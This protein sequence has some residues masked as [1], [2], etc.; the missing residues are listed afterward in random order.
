MN[1]YNS[2]QGYRG[3]NGSSN[4]AATTGWVD[5]VNIGGAPFSQWGYRLSDET[6]L[7]TC[8]LD[9]LSDKGSFSHARYLPNQSYE[10]LVRGPDSLGSRFDA[11][12]PNV[13]GISDLCGRGTPS[14]TYPSPFEL[15]TNPIHC[16]DAPSSACRYYS[17]GFD[18]EIH[19]RMGVD[20]STD[21]PTLSG[22][23]FNA[24]QLELPRCIR[25]GGDQIRSDS[26]DILAQAIKGF[27]L[28]L[29]GSP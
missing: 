21:P 16:H 10:C 28:D 25:F 2:K 15:A 6:S 19:E 8:P 7:I 20:L 13:V 5:D 22:L 27:L 11:L 24:V 3:N 9:D 12:L 26:A 1:L 29:Y 18:V 4:T 23:Y 14:S 17:G